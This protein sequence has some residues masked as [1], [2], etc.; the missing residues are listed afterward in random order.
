MNGSV[1]ARLGA[2]GAIAYGVVEIVGDSLS[3]TT[4]ST[5]TPR[6]IAAYFAGHAPTAA[7]WS[8]IYIETLGGFALLVFG[9]Y[10][11]SVGRDRRDGAMLSVLALSAGIVQAATILAG[12]PAKIEAYYRA[13][14]GMDPQIAAA[15]LDLNNA[16]F[17]LGFMPQAL[18][19]A[20]AGG[21]AIRTGVFP[22]WLGWIGIAVGIAL[23][24]V[25]GAPVGSNLHILANG[26]FFL[27]LSVT[28]AVLLWRTPSVVNSPSQV[29][30]TV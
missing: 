11:W 15:M 18:F 9:A 12:E 20:A 4:D 28:G 21:L 30:A 8:G 6:Q 5:Q 13:A 24:A 2:A 16:S 27:W 3:S 19:A 25:V 29:R 10:L 1:I 22:A 23:L 17:Y 7:T 26:I 14:Q